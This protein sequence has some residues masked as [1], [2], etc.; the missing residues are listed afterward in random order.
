MKPVVI[1]LWANFGPYHID[2]LEAATRALSA[3][4]RVVGVEIGGSSDTYAWAAPGDSPTL[5]RITLFPALAEERVPAWRCFRALLRLCWRLRPA[6]VFLCHYERAEIFLIALLLRLLGARPYCTVE[7]KFD[8]KPRRIW[9]EIG[10]TL[11]C[12]PYCGALVGGRRGSDYL[13]FLGFSADRIAFGYDTVSMARVRHLAE[14]PPAPEGRG[15]AERHFTIIARLVAKKNIAMALRAYARYCASAGA[16]A[17]ALHICGAGELEPSLREN[18]RALGITG[19]VFH[20]FVQAPE[21]ARLLASSLA[22]ILPS[23][24]EQWGLVVNEALAMGVPILCSEN[25]GA[26]DLLVRTAMNGYVVESD[27]PDG[28]A[29]FMQLLAED[30]VEWR[31]LAEGSQKLAPLA[32]TRQFGIGVRHLMGLDAA[33]TSAIRAPTEIAP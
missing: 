9:R 13:R 20:G 7:S 32:D 27:N 8:D 23:T 17:R 5:E 33:D 24:E 21:I 19:V 30:E 3:E 29:R 2:R 4:F 1:L 12:L 18:A 15:H 14:A 6:H 10:K 11:F 28:L 31:R 22:L 26:R 25:V 16:A